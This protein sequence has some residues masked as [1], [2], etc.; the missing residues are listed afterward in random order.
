MRGGERKGEERRGREGR[1]HCLKM[2]TLFFFFSTSSKRLTLSQSV[3]DWILM[4]L[5]HLG[6]SHGIKVC[7]GMYEMVEKRV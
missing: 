1:E 4:V 7:L 3:G 6:E 2:E 5:N